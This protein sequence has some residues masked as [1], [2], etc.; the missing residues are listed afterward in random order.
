MIQGVTPE[1]KVKY[2]YGGDFGERHNDGNFCMDALTYP[3]RTPH[4][5]LYEVKQVYRPVRVE[6]GDN[7]GEYRIKSL[8]CHMNAGEYLEGSYEITYDGGKREGKTFE[9]DVPALGSMDITIPEA[10]EYA[11]REAYI[12]FIFRAKE[13]LS[14]CKKGYEICFDQIQISA[15][16]KDNALMER[17]KK[18]ADPGTAAVTEEAL[19]VIVDYGTVRYCFNKRIS[20]MDS[21]QVQGE[22]LL[23]RPL[24]FNFFR[25][26]IDND[27]MRGDWYRAHLNDYVTKGYDTEVLKTG[28]G[29]EIRH[30]QS[31]GWSI[32]QPFTYMDVTYVLTSGGMDVE[33]KA[34]ATNKLT[35]LP[36]FGIRLFLPKR[37]DQVAYYGYGPY[38]SYVDKHQA[39]YMGNFTDCISNM[40]EDYIRPQENSS[41]Y[42]CKHMQVTDGRIKIT[43]A[44]DD[45]FSFNASEYTQEELAEKRHNYELVKCDSNVICVDDKMAGVG[46]AACGPQ[47]AEKYRLPL[48]KWTAEFHMTVE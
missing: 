23:D 21:I 47:L 17:Q 18:E 2:G 20:A 48:P 38:E 43:F 16:A 33:C 26:P 46:S 4:T 44:S 41:H 27:G 36:R 13:D 5:G 39:S 10:K 28:R 24:Q 22:E 19:K 30:R 45:G 7:L 35:F 12:R 42:G 40:H 14:Y 11:G 29:V 31:F 8:L 32:H 34:E 1:G 25:A 9:L 6:K 3:D 37:F 15:G